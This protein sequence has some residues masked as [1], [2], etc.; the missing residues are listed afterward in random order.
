MKKSNFECFL[1]MSV[2]YMR[3]HQWTINNTGREE[4]KHFTGSSTSCREGKS[5]ER[6]NPERKISSMQTKGDI[7]TGGAIIFPMIG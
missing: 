3:K 6:E 7:P 4:R 1:Y 2:N 5:S